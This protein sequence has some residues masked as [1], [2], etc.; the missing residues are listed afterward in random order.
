MAAITGQRTTTN[1]QSDQLARDISGDISLLEPNAQALAIWTE[2]L[3]KRRTISKKAEW[4]EDTRK[5]RFLTQSG[6][7]T[8][9]AGVIAVNAGQGTYVQQW[10]QLLNTRTGEQL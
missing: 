9:G 10:D 7:A 8:A 4:A 2:K 6:G 1:V 3:R 5:A